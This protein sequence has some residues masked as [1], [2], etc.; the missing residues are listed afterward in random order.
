MNTRSRTVRIGIAMI[1]IPLLIMIVATFIANWIAALVT[2]T[3]VA[4]VTIG[5]A[6]LL[7][8]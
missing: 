1:C 3:L 6:L 8:N 5:I 2:W 7:K 4:S